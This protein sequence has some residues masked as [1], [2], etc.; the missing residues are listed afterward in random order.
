MFVGIEPLLAFVLWL[1]P[2][3]AWA[4]YCVQQRRKKVL[5]HETSSPVRQTV[6]AQLPFRR[7]GVA[8]CDFELSTSLAPNGAES[9]ADDAY[10]ALKMNSLLR[11]DAGH[12]LVPVHGF[13]PTSAAAFDEISDDPDYW[14]ICLN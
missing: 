1:V 10:V 2:A 5:I 11:R 3:G 14:T 7:F 13:V 8:K 12:V 9:G 4:A 6:Y